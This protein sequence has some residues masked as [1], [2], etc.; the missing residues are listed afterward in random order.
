MNDIEDQS[1]VLALC[2][3]HLGR[4]LAGISKMLGGKVEAESYGAG[5]TTMDGT[6]YVNC[7]GSGVFLLGARNEYVVESVINQIHRHPLSARLLIDET[8]PRAAQALASICPEGIDKVHFVSSGTEATE[9]AI[10]L[11]RANG[12]RRLISTTNGYHGKTMGALSVTARA[13]YQDAF[14]PLIPDVVEIPYNDL[15]ALRRVLADSIPSCFIVEPVQG[16]GGVIVPSDDYLPGVSALCAEYGAFLVVDEIQTGLGRVGGTWGIDGMDVHPDVMLVGKVLSG[17]VVPVSA[18]ACTS[19]AYKPFEK[20]PLLHTSTYSGAPISAAA[21]LGTVRA[22]QVQD[23]GERSRTIGQR[24]LASFSKSSAAA[25]AGTVKEVRGKGLLIGIEFTD[26]GFAGEMLLGLIEHG[27]LANHSMNNSSVVRFTPPA[28]L[29]DDEMKIVEA[30][31][32]DAFSG[33]T[34]AET[35]LNPGETVRSSSAPA[36][37]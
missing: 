36:V 27:V 37:G 12:F 9:A 26:P 30:A 5:L 16:E 25:P 13:M 6:S 31:V 4:R 29:T 34:S 35:L 3:K 28:I 21:V 10:K 33:I 22:L 20:D 18:I 17:G 14:R 2:S 8:S 11:A 24:L 15:D 7:A 32:R 19:N 23:I 1:H